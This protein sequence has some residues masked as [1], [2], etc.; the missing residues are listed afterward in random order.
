MGKAHVI[1][2]HLNADLGSLDH[3]FDNN[4][5]TLNTFKSK[6]VLF[7]SNR[8]LQTCQ[9]VNIFI[10]N[11]CLN[12]VSRRVIHKNRTWNKQIKSLISKMNQRI[13]LLQ[14][15]KPLLTL[16]VRITL[17]NTLISPLFDYA[18]VIWGDKDNT[19]LMSDLQIM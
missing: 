10:N 14:R 1:E 15:V 16:D 6:F 8:Q 7:G 17:Y 9:G 4:Y 2:S 13:G 18:N 5:L 11:E 19:T 12:Q 3:W